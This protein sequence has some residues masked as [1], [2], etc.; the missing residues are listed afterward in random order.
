M[1]VRVNK[2]IKK[3]APIVKEQIEKSSVIAEEVVEE[4]KP[5]VKKEYKVTRKKKNETLLDN[6]NDL[7]MLLKSLEESENN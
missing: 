6:L 7:D 2:A 1:I 4:V 3:S 5:V